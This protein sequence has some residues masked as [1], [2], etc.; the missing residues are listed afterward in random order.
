[1]YKKT[2]TL[3]IVTLMS[4]SAFS[5][6]APQIEKALSDPK[7]MENEAKADVYIHRNP[8]IHDRAQKA[9]DASTRAVTCKN[10]NLRKKPTCS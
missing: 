10:I 8:V 9:P 3:I 4:F 1:M 5:Q 6:T 2:L 7:R